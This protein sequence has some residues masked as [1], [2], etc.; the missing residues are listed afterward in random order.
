MENILSFLQ[1][2]K[3][4]LIPVCMFLTVIIIG[5][6]F[7]YFSRK[8][9]MLRE[10]KKSRKK[11]VNSIKRKEYAKIIGKAKHIEVPLIAPLSGRKCVY[12][13]VTVEVKADKNWRKIID[14]VKSQD[15]FIATNT[16]KAIVKASNLDKSFKYI[17]LVKDFNKNSGFRNDAPEKLEAY[18]K[19]YSKKSTG[20]FGINKQMR[21]REGIIELDEDIAVKGVAEWKK[22][23]EPL[24][25]YSY[26]KILILTGTK[27]QKL[28]V[29]DEPKALL[30]VNVL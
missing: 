9:R 29:T 13:H 3:Q 26:S 5:L 2:N 4:V 28:L 1:E 12:Y 30:R 14:D 6:L 21:Y 19:E 27:K 10:F 8:N 20:L 11:S 23:N 15:F 16:E 24:E 7:F 18:L 25:G 22:L 17:H